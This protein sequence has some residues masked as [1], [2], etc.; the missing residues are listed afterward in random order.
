MVVDPDN[1]DY[2]DFDPS[3][4]QSLTSTAFELLSNNQ[5]AYESIHMELKK[6]LSAN[7]DEKLAKIYIKYFSK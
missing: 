7:Y 1:Y 6:C 2:S 3:L 5:K 4:L